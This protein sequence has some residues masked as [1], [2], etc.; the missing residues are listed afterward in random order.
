VLDLGYFNVTE[1]QLSTMALYVATAVLGPSV[2]L[3][4]VELLG[5]YSIQ[6]NN[7]FILLATFPMLQNIL[8]RCARQPLLIYI[9]GIIAPP[10]N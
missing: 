4:R 1:A 6:Y 10:H 3:N 2:W 8:S 7:L 5:G 9:Y